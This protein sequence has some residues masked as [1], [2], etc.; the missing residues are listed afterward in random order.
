[1]RPVRFGS[2]LLTV[3]LLCRGGG[4]GR[5]SARETGALV[6]ENSGMAMIDPNT[7]LLS[8][9]DE[10]KLW[11]SESQGAD[12]RWFWPTR[13][14]TLWASSRPRPMVALCGQQLVTT[15]PSGGYLLLDDSNLL[16]HSI[17]CDGR[18]VM[19]YRLQ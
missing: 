11:L 15:P 16:L 8:S 17:G 5:A 6:S 12:W 3:L 19:R 4:K 9:G 2:R 10:Q 1:L 18:S 14:L 7:W 13:T